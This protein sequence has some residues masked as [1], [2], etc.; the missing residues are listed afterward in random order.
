M[1]HR[2]P[3]EIHEHV[4]HRVLFGVREKR[5]GFEDVNP[6]VVSLRVL[7]IEKP[8]NFPE[9]VALSGDVEIDEIALGSAACDRAYFHAGDVARIGDR[10]LVEP[11][12]CE[13][14]RVGIAEET[15]FGC[16]DSGVERVR[17]FRN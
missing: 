9:A 8:K 3:L 14:H 4:G 1:F 5:E 7:L 16:P 13:W 17:R 10:N 2:V 15:D 6:V 12:G 11:V